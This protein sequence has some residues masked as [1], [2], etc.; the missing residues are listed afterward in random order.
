MITKDRLDRAFNEGK[1]SRKERGNLSLYC[2]TPDTQFGKLWDDATLL[3]RGIIFDSAG[4]LVALPFPKFFNLNEMPAT[5]FENLPKEEPEVSNKMD[6]SLCI[7][8]WE[9]N[10]LRFAT[11]GSFES[12]QAVEA[13]KI[14]DAKYMQVEREIPDH[15]T[16]L[17]ELIHPV[18]KVV[19]DYDY[20]DLVLIG[21]V[22]RYAFKDFTY[23]EVVSFAL[24][25]GFRYT[26]IYS[27]SLDEVVN[28]IDK[29][30]D[31]T[32][33]YVLRYSNGL[34]VKI[35]NKMYL[36]YHRLVSQFTD[37]NVWEMLRNGEYDAF[38]KDC[39]EEYIQTVEELAK[40]IKAMHKAMT[41]RVVEA[42]NSIPGALWSDK[43]FALHVKAHFN[44]I[45]PFLFA[46][47]KG[48][49]EVVNKLA[50]NMIKDKLGIKEEVSDK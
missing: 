13:M 38:I 3:A 25:Y 19:I 15:L 8:Y 36:K 43:E 14:W 48:K 42:F 47:R 7:S 4:K 18:S 39:P 20:Q 21:V 5:T 35:K 34:R 23:K 29:E 22:D 28:E 11:K 33:G 6:G 17:F 37:K 45:A 41:D 27:K 46:L 26:D 1:V 10:G 50:F 2:Y 12:E 31:N 30:F 44:D 24:K 16:L 32:E 49:M 9:G 40:D